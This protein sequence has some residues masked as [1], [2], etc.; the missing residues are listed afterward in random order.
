MEKCLWIISGKCNILKNCST[1]KPT[2]GAI[3]LYVPVSAVMTPSRF[4]NREIPKSHTFTT[5]EW[6]NKHKAWEYDN[7]FNQQCQLLWTPYTNEIIFRSII[8]EYEDYE[9]MTAKMIILYLKK[10]F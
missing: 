3:H 9:A 10:L 4:W 1:Y 8:M 2:S 6:T 5:F 7:L